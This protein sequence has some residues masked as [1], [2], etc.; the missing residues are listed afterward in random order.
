MEMEFYTYGGFDAVVNGFQKVSLM[1]SSNELRVLGYVAAVLGLLFGGLGLY[2]RAFTGRQQSFLLV[3]APW[4][5]GLVV[6]FFLVTNIG[7][8]HIYDPVKNKY[9]AVSLPSAVVAVVGGLNTI[10]RGLV[11]VVADSGDPSSFLTQ[12]WGTGLL[13]MYYLHNTPLARLLPQPQS[14]TL[15]NYVDECVTFEIG[16]PG[17]N[18][19]IE[20]LN[21][22]PDL[23][24]PLSKAQNPAIFTASHL[25]SPEGEAASCTQIWQGLSP[26]LTTGVLDSVCRQLGYADNPEGLGQCRTAIHGA[27]NALGMPDSS[28]D[29]YALQSALAAHLDQ[30]YA[31]GDLAGATAFQRGKEL[32]SGLAGAMV[33][34]PIAK[35]VG[36]AIAAAMVPLLSLLLP[37]PLFGR[38]LAYSLSGF[39]FLTVWGVTDAVIYGF[40]GDFAFQSFDAI[41]ASG[42]GLLSFSEMPGAIT[43]I[44]AVFGTMMMASAS[45]SATVTAGLFRIGSS[46]VAAAVSAQTGKIEQATGQGAEKTIDPA[47]SAGALEGNLRATPTKTFSNEHAFEARSTAVSAQME[48]QFSR[49]M[50]A[51]QE[52]GGVPGYAGLMGATGTTETRKQRGEATLAAK[53]RELGRMSGVSDPQSDEMFAGELSAGGAFSAM[54]RLTRVAGETGEGGE[55]VPEMYWEGR[56]A[57]GRLGASTGSTEQ[58]WTVYSPAPG[59]TNARN[60]NMQAAAVDGRLVS[61]QGDDIGLSLSDVSREAYTHAIADQRAQTA[62]IDRSI[63]YG[64]T[65]MLS[66]SDTRSR[67]DAAAET[68]RRE[69][70]GSV[71]YSKAFTEH[72]NRVIREA[73]SITDSHGRKISK[74]DFIKLTAE[75]G[76][77]KFIGASVGVEGGKSYQYQTEDGDTY[78]ASVSA[79]K[80]RSLDESL[81]KTIRDTY[82]TAKGTA[83]SSTGQ[84]ALSEITS[85]TGTQTIMEQAATSA[86]KTKSLEER[87]S[88]EESSGITASGDYRAAWYQHIAD[89]RFDGDWQRAVNHVQ[90]LKA[91]GEHGQIVEL[92]RDFVLDT[93]LK[94]SPVGPVGKEIEGPQ[95]QGPDFDDVNRRF[96]ERRVELGK[97]LQ[98]SP[99]I[100]V[101]ENVEDRIRRADPRQGVTGPNATRSHR[102]MDEA[103]WNVRA[104]GKEVERQNQGIFSSTRGWLPEELGGERHPTAESIRHGGAPEGYANPYQ[105]DKDPEA[106]NRPIFDS[107]GPRETRSIAGEGPLKRKEAEQ[108]QIQR[109]QLVEPPQGL[110]RGQEE[111]SVIQNHAPLPA[112]SQVQLKPQVRF[113]QAN[114]VEV[115][116]DAS[117]NF[118]RL[119]MAPPAPPAPTRNQEVPVTTPSSFD[120]KTPN[121]GGDNEAPSRPE[122]SGGS[123]SF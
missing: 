44:F 27:A 65:S 59:H 75:A 21:S 47:G 19:T 96:S 37:T 50:G 94:P 39:L 9:Q 31:T 11:Q 123:K 24:V 86:A 12:G 111:Q 84:K 63:G 71:D 114:P 15:L 66:S 99:K 82:T 108:R 55:K 105:V 69:T 112:K 23:R 77:P 74:E 92:M 10:E 103:A 76:T 68:L 6:Y 104:G 73:D 28:A 46:A 1:F 7:V 122:P 110:V 121:T 60:G 78:T 90:G 117:P 51:V 106:I 36:W 119:Q 87:Q 89:S 54:Q 35:G 57:D 18:L 26:A 58:G 32:F 80:S 67:V 40:A 20:E 97:E 115:K 45:L 61:I 88:K 53:Q 5:A 118:D 2:M 81:G 42:H 48:G 83:L 3:Y 8:L 93:N 41:R 101:P 13:G 4:L 107:P 33:W 64:L 98:S 85:I 91:K 43:K 34:M 109:D 22:A 14:S 17:T 38:A 29:A 56:V 70:Q 79:E 62:R 120:S 102:E 116:D 72:Q 25:Y 30:V 95:G 49:T 52:A 16:R 113:S 100:K